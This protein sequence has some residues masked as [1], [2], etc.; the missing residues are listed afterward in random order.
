MR[1]KFPRWECAWI[2]CGASGRSVWLE[3]MREGEDEEL[4]VKR[5]VPQVL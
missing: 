5:E 1:A 3:G 4:E 2:A